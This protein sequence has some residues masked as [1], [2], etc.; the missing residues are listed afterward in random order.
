MCC[1]VLCNA[2]CAFRDWLFLP[3][4]LCLSDCL[5]SVIAASLF[6]VSCCVNM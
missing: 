1:V 2:C 5:A 3:C 4:C 6:V